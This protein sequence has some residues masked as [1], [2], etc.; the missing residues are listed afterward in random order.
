MR[1]SQDVSDAQGP[2]ELSKEM[3]ALVGLSEWKLTNIKKKDL[4]EA[5]ESVGLPTTGGLSA[6]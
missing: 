2:K 1:A 3:A 4:E 5:C 6:H